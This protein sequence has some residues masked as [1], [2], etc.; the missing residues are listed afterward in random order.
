VAAGSKYETALPND[1]A[2]L[3]LGFYLRESK[4]GISTCT[5]VFIAALLTIAPN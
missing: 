2:I 4:V 5:P 3:L 1:P